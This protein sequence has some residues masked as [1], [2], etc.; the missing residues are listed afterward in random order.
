ML[1][2]SNVIIYS[3]SEEHGPLRTSI[4]SIS[5]AASEISR[6]EVLGYSK[7]SAMA[8]GFFEELFESFTMYPIS[9][10]VISKAIELRQ[11]KKMSLGDSIVAAT[12][13][14]HELV[15]LT[16]NTKDFT[17]IP[18]LLVSDPLAK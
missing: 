14:V 18:G 8:K 4:A 15:L 9:E 7:L 6:V 17:W 12:A 2:D 3:A 13:V 10:D 16:H 5:P 1:L 11:T